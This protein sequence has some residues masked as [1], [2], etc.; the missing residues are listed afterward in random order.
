M[1]SKF[2]DLPYSKRAHDVHWTYDNDNYDGDGDGDDNQSDNNNDND[3][4]D[5]NDDDDDFTV[6]YIRQPKPTAYQE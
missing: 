4:D 6:S 1:Q 3:N 5:D 2:L